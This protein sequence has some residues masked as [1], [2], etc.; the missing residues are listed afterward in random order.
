MAK[1]LC[2]RTSNA[3][4]R[5]HARCTKLAEYLEA[6]LDAGDAVKRRKRANLIYQDLQ[7]NRISHQRAA[8]ELQALNKRQKGGWAGEYMSR[9]TG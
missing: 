7:D 4:A 5:K 9:L 1:P 2:Q 6:L 8:L 3:V